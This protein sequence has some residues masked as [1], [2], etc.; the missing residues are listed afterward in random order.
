MKNWLT[1]SLFLPLGVSAQDL[2][3]QEPQDRTV[4][5]EE[6]TAINC[7]NC[8]AGHV[9]GY[10]LLAAHPGTAVAVELH[11]GGLAEPSGG[12][13]EFRTTWSTALWSHYGVNSQPRGAINR[14]PVNGQTV[15]STTAWTNAVNGALALPSPVNIGISSTF[16]AGPRTLTVNVELYYTQ[17][18]L[19]GNDRIAVLLKESHLIGYQQDYQN[20]AQADY[21]H[22]NVLRAYLTDLWGDEVATTTQGTLVSRTYTFT[23]PEGWDIANCEVVAFVSEYQG[24]IYQARAVG[25]DGGFTTAIADYSAKADLLP[26]PVPASD[27]IFIPLSVNEAGAIIR[28]TDSAGRTVLQTTRTSGLRA[29]DVATVESG[30][31]LVSIISGSGNRAARVLVQH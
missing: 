25:A 3:S 22:K 7:G 17:D 18:G 6:Y 23:V 5:L 24:E 8:P 21:D 20:G 26:Y 29:L 28:L 27:H 10:G 19:G 15:I 9:V 30:S 16:D 12:Q 1:L 31:Y 13:P 14:I 2:V 11:G 4:L